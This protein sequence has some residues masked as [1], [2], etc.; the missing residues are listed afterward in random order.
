MPWLCPGMFQSLATLLHIAIT[1]VNPEALSRFVACRLILLDKCPGV[2]LFGVS[3]VPRRIIVKAILKIIGGEVKEA[4]GS[5]KLCAG[6]DGSCEAV[7]HAMQSIF[8]TPETEA[9][10]LVDDN[11]TFNS[12]HR[13]AALHNISIICLSLIWTLKNTYRAPARLLITGSGDIFSTEK[14]TQAIF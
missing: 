5:L 6:Q 2:R 8:Q 4:A 13:K 12:L 7:V 11:N 3:E 10:H 14:N 1:S 9:V